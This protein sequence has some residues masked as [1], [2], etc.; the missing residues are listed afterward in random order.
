MSTLS[1]FHQERRSFQWPLV[2][3]KSIAAKIL[4]EY[5]AKFVPLCCFC[6]NFGIPQKLY[7]IME[8]FHYATER[9]VSWKINAE[10]IFAQI[11]WTWKNT[12]KDKKNLISLMQKRCPSVLFDCMRWENL[13]LSQ[14]WHL[15]KSASDDGVKIELRPVLAQFKANLS[16]P[17]PE[18]LL[19]GL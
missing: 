2:R 17:T 5:L 11:S 16:F 6:P 9:D 12:L 14:K 13:P 7:K 1:K 3:C 8:Y 10:E 15:Q 19:S 18:M 4:W